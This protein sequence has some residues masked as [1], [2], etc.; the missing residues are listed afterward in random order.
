MPGNQCFQV[1]ATIGLARR[2][3]RVPLLPPEWSYRP[4]FSFPDYLFGNVAGPESYTLPDLD[5]IHPTY[6]IYMQDV[7]LFDA[8]AEE[9]RRCFVPTAHAMSVIDRPTV[10]RLERLGSGFLVVHVR[11]GDNVYQPNHYPLPSLRYYLDAI[12]AHPNLAVECFSDD[13]SWC[14]FVLEPEV[15]RR[16]REW[17]LHHGVPRPKEHEPDYR[18]APVLDWIDLCLMALGEHFVLSNSTM[19]LFAAWLADSTDVTVPDP[20]YGPALAGEVDAKLLYMPA[21]KAADG[22]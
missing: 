2:H 3:N 12:D 21:W 14:H 22:S 16:G 13:P 10:N 9:I 18:T 20:W 17:H 5:H 8:C 1:A 15:R 6:R 11:R 19:G 4:F 7:S